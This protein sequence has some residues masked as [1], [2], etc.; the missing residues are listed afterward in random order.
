MEARLKV[1]PKRLPTPPLKPTRDIKVPEKVDIPWEA[2]DWQSDWK[3]D[4]EKMVERRKRAVE[5]MRLHHVVKNAYTP[6][7]EE[8]LITMFTRGASL[9]E[10]AKSLGRTERAVKSKLERLRKVKTIEREVPM[11]RHYIKRKPESEIVRRNHYTPAQDAVIVEMRAQGKTYKEIA[12][13]IGR[14]K[15]AIRRRYYRIQG[16]C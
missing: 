9:E 16:L 2:H 3:V 13:E 5:G 8:Q 6:E 7:Q 14:D 15:E 12:E 4:R 11:Q 10:I 1:D